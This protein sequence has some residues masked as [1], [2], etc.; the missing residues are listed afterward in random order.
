MTDKKN[1]SAEDVKKLR[2]QTGASIMECKKALEKSGGNL[3]EAIKYLRQSGKEKAGKKSERQ[4]GEG[5]IASY[6]HSNKKV[7]SMVELRCET[8]FVAKNSEFQELAYD[9]AMHV[10]AMA[11]RYVSIKKIEKND[12]DEYEKIVREEVSGEKKPADII[13]KI[14]EG[15]I[16]KHFAEISL[17]SQPFV[18]NN[19]MTI[20]DLIKEKIAKIGENIQIGRIERFEI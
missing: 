18:K 8:D 2:E 16:K 17:M 7:G 10:A 9:I 11:P 14:V 3:E 4:T 6:I 20:E 13:E 1:I 12:L 19:E 5:V 15:K